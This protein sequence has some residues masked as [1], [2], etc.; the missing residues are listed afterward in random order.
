MRGIGRLRHDR[1]L[2][3]TQVS[4]RGGEGEGAVLFDQE[5]LP[6][7]QGQRQTGSFQASHPAANREARGRA[8][9]ANIRDRSAGQL[10]F[11][12][13]DG[14]GLRGIGRLR[15]DRDLVTTQVS[16]RGGEGEGAVLFDQERLPVIQGQRQTGSFQASH[17]AANRESSRN[18]DVVQ[19]Q[20]R[21]GTASSRDPVIAP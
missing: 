12:V 9:H 7:I 19:T 15:H 17:P 11:A 3:T 5:R 20:L 16:Q 14:A 4:Q 2:V 10:T 21:P 6:A 13:A 8:S 18:Q 1:D